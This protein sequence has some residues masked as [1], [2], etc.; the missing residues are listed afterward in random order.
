MLYDV[1]V[2]DKTNK[3]ITRRNSKAQKMCYKQKEIKTSR[4]SPDC[5]RQ[6]SKANKTKT[7]KNKEKEKKNF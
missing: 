4:K 3:T 6:T 5:K 1:N 7:A 2:I